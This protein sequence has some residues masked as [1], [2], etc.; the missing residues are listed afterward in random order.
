MLLV[1]DCSEDVH[2]VSYISVASHDFVGHIQTVQD[3]ASDQ[4]LYCLLTECSMKI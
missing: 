1:E 4:G 3:A 2:Q